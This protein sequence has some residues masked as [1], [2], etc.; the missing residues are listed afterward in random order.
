VI[1]VATAARRWW[2]PAAAAIGA[3]VAIALVVTAPEDDV[4]LLDTA[5]TSAGSVAELAG[6]A[7]PASTD[8]F[9]TARLDD[10]SQMDVTFTLDTGETELFV[11]GSDLAEPVT[12]QRVILHSSPLWEL[13]P[14]D[15]TVHGTTDRYGRLV[16]LVELVEEGDRT[17]VR[18][19]LRPDV[20]DGGTD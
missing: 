19:S 3:V 6:L 18:I 17:R 1:H 2:L 9:L 16:R 14:A 20:A 4:P 10:G 8:E 5:D 13:N 12:G 15:G 11:S 7:L